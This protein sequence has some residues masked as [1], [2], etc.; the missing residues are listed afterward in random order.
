[1]AQAL[2][3]DEH[4]RRVM[5]SNGYSPD[6]QSDKI[7]AQMRNVDVQLNNVI[8]M[9]RVDVKVVQPNEFTILTLWDRKC[10][11]LIKETADEIKQKMIDEQCLS[12]TAEFDPT[13]LGSITLTKCILPLSNSQVDGITFEDLSSIQL[14]STR[15]GK[16]HIKT[17]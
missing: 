2:R 3:A 14:S 16:N 6:W 9:F 15:L 10:Y 11:A 7:L 4:L 8:L 1:M 17:E 13:L 12:A 5:G